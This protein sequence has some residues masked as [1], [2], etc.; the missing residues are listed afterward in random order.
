MGNKTPPFCF[1]YKEKELKFKSFNREFFE[2][3]MSVEDMY[4]LY[5]KFLNDTEY[6]IKQKKERKSKNIQAYENY[7]NNFHKIYSKEMDEDCLIFE[8]EEKG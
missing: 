6:Q 4:T 7:L 1:K 5:E 3:I 8:F 2:F